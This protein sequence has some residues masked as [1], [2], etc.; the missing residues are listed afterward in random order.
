MIVIDS[1]IAT[2]WIMPDEHSPTANRLLPVAAESSAIVPSL[3][4]HELRNTLLVGERRG[5]LKPGDALKGLNLVQKIGLATDDEG[6][7]DAVLDLARRHMLTA[8]D[9]AYLELALRRNAA[10]ATLDK[11]LAAAGRIEKLTV[12][13]EPN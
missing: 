4:W 5:R 9:S 6:T 10:L 13:S 12:L 8:Y 7:H 11:R 2:G 1:S 3:F